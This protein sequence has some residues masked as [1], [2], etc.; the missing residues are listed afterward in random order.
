MLKNFLILLLM[1]TATSSFGQREIKDQSLILNNGTDRDVTIAVNLG[2]PGQPK[3]RYNVTTDVWEF[4]HDG[5]TWQTFVGLEYA[6]GQ[7]ALKAPLASPS[8]A[9]T[10]TAPTPVAGDNSTTIATTAYTDGAVATQAALDD[11]RLDLLE[12]TSADHETR[13]DTLE[14][15]LPAHIADTTTHGTNGNVVGTSDVQTLTN[16][17]IDADSN[18][19]SNIDVGEL[20]SGVLDPDLGGVSAAHDTLPSAKAV[21]DYVDTEVA[22]GGSAVAAHLSDTIDAHDASA[23]SN[24]ASGNLTA[25]DVQAALNEHQTDIDT[26]NANIAT[27]ASTLAGLDSTY[28][29]DAQLTAH[30]ADTS[31]H[32]VTTVAGLTETQTF[33][34]K[35]LTSPVINTA[36]I[37]DPV[38]SDVKKD[39]YANLVTYAATATEGQLVYSTDTDEMFQIINNAL[40][41]VGGGGGVGGTDVMFVQDFESAVAG[42][43]ATLTGWALNTTS[44]LHGE[45]DLKV[46]HATSSTTYTIKQSGITVPAK[47]REKNVTIKITAKSSATAG[48]LVMDAGCTTDTDLLSGESLDFS[49]LTG[50]NEAFASFDIPSTCTSLSYTVRALPETGPPVSSIDDVE[51]YITKMTDVSS[52]L[53]QDADSYIR[54]D[55]YAGYGS[56]NTKIMRFSGLRDSMGDA[57]GY[58]DSATEGAKFVANKS[59][60]YHFSFSV[61]GP[62]GMYGLAGLSKNLSGTDLSTGA[63][64]FASNPEKFLQMAYSPAVTG[65]SGIGSVEWSGYLNAGDIV[66]PHTDGMV[67]VSADRVHFTAAYQGSLKQVTVNKN[68]KIKIPT[69]EVRFEGTASRGTGAQSTVIAFDTISKLTGDAFEID[70]HGT[71]ST[72]GRHVKMKKS[73]K[74]TV[75]SAIYSGS[76]GV[77]AWITKNQQTLN[78]NPLDSEAITRSYYGA[79]DVRMISGSFDVVAGDIIRVV[80]DFAPGNTPGDNIHFSFMETDI[81]VS[82]SNTLPQWSETDLVVKAAGNAGQTITAGA[83]GNDIPFITVSDT[84]GGAWNGST[85]TVPETGTYTV[86]GSTFFTTSATQRYVELFVNG[87]SYRGVSDVNTNN[88]NSFEITDQFTKGQV[89]SLRSMVNAGTLTND[90]KYHW[91][92]ITKAGKGNVTGIDVT[93]FVNVPV[94]EMQS[95]YLT[96]ST[97]FAANSTITGALT[98]IAGSSGIYSYNSTTGLYT[99]IKT[100]NFNLRLSTSGPGETV[101]TIVVN[102]ADVGHDN[103]NAAAGAWAT[104]SHEEILTAGSTFYFKQYSYA[105]N[106]ARVSVSAIAVPDTIVTPVESFSTDTATFVHKTTAVTS[107]DAVGTFNTF[108]YPANTNTRTICTS[109]PTQT[110]PS[111]N[112]DGPRIYGR[113]SYT[114]VTDCNTPVAIAIQIGKGFK[115]LNIN[116]YGASSKTLPVSLDLMTFGTAVRGLSAKNYNELTGILTL[117][118][119]QDNGPAQTAW[120]FY[121]AENNVQYTSSFVAINA[122][123]TPT[124]SGI[125]YVAPRVAY[126]SDVRASGTSGGTSAA[127]TTQTRVLNTLDDPSGIVQNASSFTGTGGSNTQFTLLS[128]E[129]EA[130]CSAPAISVGYNK[131]KLKNVTDGVDVIIGSN[132]YSNQTTS[133]AS[134]RSFVRGKF[135]ISATKTFELQHHTVTSVAGGLGAANSMGWNEVYSQCKIT[136]VK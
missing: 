57:I 96:N 77:N 133:Y 94:A 22:A 69:S 113:Q 102:G 131:A 125:S 62:S 98:R 1:V 49:S 71:Y 83:A 27:N 90:S 33:T 12:T 106:Q 26:A 103:A 80:A 46:T 99:V 123:K 114:V 60:I 118:A 127:N 48:N 74:L 67:P 5:S 4:S 32:G 16:K 79:A 53:V 119:G 58:F 18:T 45:Q 70:P 29:T 130:E 86:R 55:T 82:V 10:P 50:G 28:A 95:S 122:S 42:D 3:L 75:S 132:E 41:P 107:S 36:H 129:Y 65:N 34:N 6:N 7:L 51:I 61:V 15:D 121:G 23:I 111:M 88:G 20:K 59:G 8:F 56:T 30:E 43:F 54:L 97:S 39:T 116:G 104:T 19:V 25:T 81:Q 37:Q 120:Y 84:T 52:A 91:L 40:E 31:T 47:F 112:V 64:S 110:I 92:T 78:A 134:T 109:A 11:A 108:Y 117:D 73:G 9:G 68:Q 136:K 72:Y 128:G 124:L 87:S 24:V 105:S 66:R 101:P 21:K 63:T 14:T 115:G 13:V 2:L 44:P 85:F 93:P 38:R 35:T 76:S 100:A 126:L 17:T 135:T 89:L